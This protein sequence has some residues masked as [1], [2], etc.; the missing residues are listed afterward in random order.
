MAARLIV[1]PA[2]YNCLTPVLIMRSPFLSL[3]LCLLFALFSSLKKY[4]KRSYKHLH[5]YIV[6]GGLSV[7]KPQIS[8]QSLPEVSAR[9]NTYGNE[10]INVSTRFE[11]IENCVRFRN[12][13]MFSHFTGYLQCQLVF[14]QFKTVVATA[15]SAVPLFR[16]MSY[17]FII[18][19]PHHHRVFPCRATLLLHLFRVCCR[20]RQM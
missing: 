2:I 5:T 15:E 14:C 4:I 6:F 19:L 17:L 12:Y 8:L 3:S 11:F 10:L 16:A 1:R 20:R 9:I 13:R 7:K 18:Y